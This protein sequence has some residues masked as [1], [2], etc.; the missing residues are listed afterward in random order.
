[1]ISK[2]F[3]LRCSV[4]VFFVW[5][6]LFMFKQKAAGYHYHPPRIIVSLNIDEI[7]VINIPYFDCK[8]VTIVWIPIMRKSNDA[9]DSSYDNNT[10]ISQ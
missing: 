1:M 3:L 2:L 10:R 5:C 7:Y 9:M 6:C 8:I 4:F